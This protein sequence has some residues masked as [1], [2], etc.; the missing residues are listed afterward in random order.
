[1][2]CALK[3]RWFW[4]DFSVFTIDLPPLSGPKLHCVSLYL[5]LSCLCSIHINWSN[6]A[7]V[8]SHVF[9]FRN[10]KN[11]RWKTKHTEKKTKQNKW[12]LLSPSETPNTF[13][14]TIPPIFISEYLRIVY[15]LLKYTPYLCSIAHWTAFFIRRNT[16]HF[17]IKLPSY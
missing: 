12:S 8:H 17:I 7:A 6:I 11:K 3:F 10:E 15:L 1:M 13:D 9:L 16:P 5:L 2:K 4:C 14:F